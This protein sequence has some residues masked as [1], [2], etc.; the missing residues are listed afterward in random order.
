MNETMTAQDIYDAALKD[1]AWKSGREFYVQDNWHD[2][3]QTLAHSGQ[4][5]SFSF[6]GVGR[7]VAY[8]FDEEIEVRL[9]RQ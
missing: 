5:F 6:Q 1:D 4:G 9:K 8:F 3:E 2:L 7:N